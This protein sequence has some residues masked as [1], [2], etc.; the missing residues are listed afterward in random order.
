MTNLKSKRGQFGP[1][2]GR[3]WT[4]VLICNHNHL[5]KK[6]SLLSLSTKS[7]IIFG[8]RI[9]GNAKNWAQLA[10]FHLA[11]ALPL[12]SLPWR[13]KELNSWNF[14]RAAQTLPT[15][16]MT[17]PFELANESPPWRFTS[18]NQLQPK[19]TKRPSVKVTQV[20]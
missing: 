19:Q 16:E 17:E 15:F 1:V 5:I 14:N 20:N 11:E 6:M 4:P 2:T 13:S 3:H 12:Q 10:G 9:L 18:M 8:L 7:K